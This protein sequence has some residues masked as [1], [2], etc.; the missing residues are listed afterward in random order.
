M[1]TNMFKIKKLI[2]LKT[3]TIALQYKIAEIT[4]L[5][6]IDISL[7]LISTQNYCI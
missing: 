2:I 4:N 7:Y 6:M 3:V 5:R 1:M